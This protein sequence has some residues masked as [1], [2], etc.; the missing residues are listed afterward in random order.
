MPLSSAARTQ[1]N[2][3]K[4]FFFPSFR[5]FP[6]KSDRQILTLLT[7]FKGLKGPGFQYF[8]LQSDPREPPPPP[9]YIDVTNKVQKTFKTTLSF[10]QKNQDSDK[11]CQKPK[12]ASIG[13]QKV[14]KGRVFIDRE[15]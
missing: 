6:R 14:I 12:T 4:H 9:Q 15:K 13:F 7:G 1:K 8:R 11:G 2:S 3:A 5:T 10:M